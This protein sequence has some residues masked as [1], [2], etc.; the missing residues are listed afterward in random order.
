MGAMRAA[1][2]QTTSAADDGFRGRIEQWAVPALWALA[3]M[4]LASHAYLQRFF[5]H[6]DALISLRFARNFVKSGALEWNLGERVEGYTNFLHILFSSALMALGVEAVASIRIVN[7]V[8]ALA[9][10]AGCWHI[11]AQF[12]TGEDG[13]LSRTLSAVLCIMTVP[14]TVWVWGGLEAVMA[15]ALLTLGIGSLLPLARD[16]GR[17]Q[18][19][20]LL[21]G[22]LVAGAIMTRPDCVVAAGAAMVALLFLG[23]RPIEVR[24]KPL[25]LAGLVVGGLVLAHVA[26]RY[27]YYGDLLPNTFYAKVGVPLGLRLQNGGPYLLGALISVPVLWLASLVMIVSAYMGRATTAMWTLCAAMLAHAAYVVW[28]GGDHMPAARLFVPIMGLAAVLVA[29]GVQAQPVGARLTLTGV[30]IGLALY[31]AVST[32]V[33]EKDGAAFVGTI[34]G[35]HLEKT[36]LPG[37]LVAL[38]TA[39]STP[40]AAPSLRFVDTLGLVDRAIAQRKPL[41]MLSLN[42]RVPGHAKGWGAYVLVRQPEIVILGMAYGTDVSTPWSLT[43]VELMRSDEFHRCYQ[44]EIFLLPYSEAEA[45]EMKGFENP[46]KLTIYRRS[47]PVTAPRIAIGGFTMPQ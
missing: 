23:A 19:R 39:G 38:T 34:V 6:D 45:R 42:Q 30:C 33:Q 41:P 13:R 11:V 8:F 7:A 31:G 21:A 40:Y 36:E 43:D 5:L 1:T 20:P 25:A 14:V 4:V 22:V 26:W 47:C 46:I 29:L 32:R 44:R 15:A 9:L 12:A 16:D 18:A 3:L 37:T 17:G 27:S 2:D 10:F 24:I 28:A 35:R